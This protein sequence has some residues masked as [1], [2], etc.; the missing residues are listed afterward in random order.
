MEITNCSS[1]EFEACPIGRNTCLSKP[2]SGEIIGPKEKLVTVYLLIFN[3]A[4]LCVWICT[5][6]HTEKGALGGQRH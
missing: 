1:S 4:Y 6:M 5:H 2:M 3:Y